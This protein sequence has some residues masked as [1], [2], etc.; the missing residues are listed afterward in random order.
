MTPKNSESYNE[1]GAALSVPTAQKVINTIGLSEQKII[2]FVALHMILLGLISV[3]QRKGPTQS[4]KQM[5]VTISM[6]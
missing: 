4:C 5:Q 2:H 6:K 1:K 3:M